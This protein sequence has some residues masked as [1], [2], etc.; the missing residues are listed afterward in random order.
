MCV[1]VFQ[2]T[3]NGQC[4]ITFFSGLKTTGCENFRDLLEALGDSCDEKSQVGDACCPGLEFQGYASYQQDKQQAREQ[5]RRESEA[6]LLIRQGG[7]TEH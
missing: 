5:M 7:E 4:R 6:V 1:C 3:W 2:G